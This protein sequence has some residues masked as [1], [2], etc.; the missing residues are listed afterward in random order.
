MFI[1]RPRGTTLE[2]TPTNSWTSPGASSTQTGLGTGEMSPPLPTRRDLIPPIKHLCF[3][4]THVVPCWQSCRTLNMA[5]KSYKL[6]FIHV[7][8]KVT[9]LYKYLVAIFFSQFEQSLFSIFIL[10]YDS[11]LFSLFIIDL[12]GTNV[13]CFLFHNKKLWSFYLLTVLV[14]SSLSLVIF[15][16]VNQTNLKENFVN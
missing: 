8:V 10:A 2:P 1:H 7:L 16:L 3:E 14:V 6:W 4:F 5:A 12:L 15:S 13:I 11:I 9:Y